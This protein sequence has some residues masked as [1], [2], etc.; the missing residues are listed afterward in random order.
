MNDSIEKAIENLTKKV[1]SDVKSDD[2][3][4]YTQ[5]ALNIAHTQS[6]LNQTKKNEDNK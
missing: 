6:V 3:L 2:A 4:R 5:A 1:S